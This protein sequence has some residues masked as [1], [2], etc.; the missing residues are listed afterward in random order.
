[1]SLS[2]QMT[3]NISDES[4]FY[5]QY[6]KADIFVGD[7]SRSLHLFSMLS[8]MVVFGVIKPSR[9]MD[10]RNMDTDVPPNSIRSVPC[11]ACKCC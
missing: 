4:S 2:K 8:E 1:M 7:Y 9:Q 10:L 6:I 11:D 3:L 5:S